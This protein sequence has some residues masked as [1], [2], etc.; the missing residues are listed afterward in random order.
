MKAEMQI[1]LY[2]GAWVELKRWEEAASWILALN[3]LPPFSPSLPP[4]L[5]LSSALAQDR[6]NIP[7]KPV[8]TAARSPSLPPSLLLWLFLFPPP[9][10][11]PPAFF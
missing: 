9:P 11:L 5:P 8:S 4:S 1:Y 2:K 10:F 7:L 6:I 3:R